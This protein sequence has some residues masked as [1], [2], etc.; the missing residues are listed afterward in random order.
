M[1]INL[2]S[3]IDLYKKNLFNLQAELIVLV[4][5][6]QMYK[7]HLIHRRPHQIYLLSR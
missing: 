6:Y 1:L 7:Q 5:G 2:S 4:S 3:D